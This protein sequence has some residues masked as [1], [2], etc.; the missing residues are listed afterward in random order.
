MNGSRD[1]LKTLAGNIVKQWA[2]VQS[3]Q[4]ELAVIPPFAYLSEIAAVVQ[5]AIALGA[6]SVSEHASGAYTGEIAA[7]MLTDIGCQYVLVGHSERR[8]LFGE[9]DQI[10]AAKYFA[11]EAAG[12]VPILCVGE[13]EAERDGGETLA[14]IARQMES[15]LALAAMTERAVL[16]YE[17]VWA[18]GTGK[19]ATPEQA[20]EV[21][22]FIRSRIGGNA[23]KVRIL[24]GGSV[25]GG[26]AEAILAMPDIDGALVG[27]ASLKAD[28]FIAIARAAVAKT[29][30]N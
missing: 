22:A 24:Y 21:H 19:S 16:A 10:V 7:S 14:V 8:A 26:N 13:S 20:Q 6:Q 27:G 5:G 29:E 11:A 1:V 3:D 2:E 28:E 9:S 12:L 23:D 17:P 15:V 25:N 18:I 30:A 4:V